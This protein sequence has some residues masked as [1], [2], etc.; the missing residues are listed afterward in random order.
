M[1]TRA[2]ASQAQDYGHPGLGSGL[3]AYP[4][5]GFDSGRSSVAARLNQLRP[6]HPTPAFP[7]SASLPDRNASPTAERQRYSASERPQ[8]KRNQL[9]DRGFD[10]GRSFVA[11]RLNQLRPDHPTPAQPSN[12]SATAQAH[13]HKASATSLGDRGFDSGRS[14]LAARLNHL[15]RA[16]LPRHIRADSTA[17]PEKRRKNRFLVRLSVISLCKPPCETHP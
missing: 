1:G 4:Q 5:D 10:S 14:F 9:R 15:W 6:D 13:D 8:G 16:R 12:A 7:P 3:V 17:F 2:P 11:A